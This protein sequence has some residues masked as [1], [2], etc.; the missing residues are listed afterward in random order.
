[1]AIESVKNP[2]EEELIRKWQADYFEEK[3]KEL[4]E[5]RAKTKIL[6]KKALK[7]LLKMIL[8]RIIQRKV[9]N[10]LLTNKTVKRSS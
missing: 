3:Q 1:M 5:K 6:Q 10:N 4:E 9:L 2:E 7:T 8:R